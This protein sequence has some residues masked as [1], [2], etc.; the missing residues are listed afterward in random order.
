MELR[1]LLG[2]IQFRWPLDDKEAFGYTSLALSE[3]SEM[4]IYIVVTDIIIDMLIV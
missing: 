1:A 2:Y 4:E 3:W